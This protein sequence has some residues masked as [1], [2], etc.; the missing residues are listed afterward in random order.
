MRTLRL[1]RSTRGQETF[2]EW[3][4]S[5]HCQTTDGL[6]TEEVKSEGRGVALQAEG[7]FKLGK[8]FL[9]ARGTDQGNK[10][11]IQISDFALT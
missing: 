5:T 11:Q 3:H 2:L 10:W 7:V 1:G 6:R 9:A 4:I 8:T